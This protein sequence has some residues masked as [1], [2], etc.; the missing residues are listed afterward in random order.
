MRPATFTFA[1]LATFAVAVPA[2]AQ[3]ERAAAVER[4]DEGRTAM[5]GGNLE[6]ACSKFAETNRLDPA[7]GTVFNLANCEEQ[8]GR[9]ATAWA[10]FKDVA[11]RM[12]ADDP[13]LG[14]AQERIS[15]LSPRVP[16]LVL[17]NDP[18]APPGTRARV[19]DR[20]IASSSFGLELP[21]DPGNHRVL[22][23]VPNAPARTVEV[24]IVDGE[25]LR[26]NLVPAAETPPNVQEDSPGGVPSAK[27]HPV[28]RRR[29]L[30]LDQKNTALVAGGVGI[31]GLAVGIIAGVAGLSAQDTG[32][33]NCSSL[34]R[35]CN[36]RGYDANQRAKAMAAVSSV[37]FV[38][39]IVGGGAATYLFLTAPGAGTSERAASVGIGGHW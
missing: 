29:I 11:G 35:T 22:V 4:F 37:G 28:T 31:A 33:D 14:V 5:Q 34:T 1:L 36:Q 6:V 27:E 13:R 24:T 10:L 38:V 8:R 30:G 17:I 20:E 16:R 9:L 25:T 18:Q 32:N 3:S 21:V 23:H 2:A 39:G 12:K 15:A 19:D 26:I 7:V